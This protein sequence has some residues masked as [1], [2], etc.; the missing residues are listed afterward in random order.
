MTWRIVVLAAYL[1][2]AGCSGLGYQP[3]PGADAEPVRG[4]PA[5]GGGG[6][7]AGM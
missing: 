6:D 2:V 3:P 4:G 5:G 1:A 7:G